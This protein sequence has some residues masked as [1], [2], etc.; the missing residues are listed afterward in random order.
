MAQLTKE[1]EF[2][3]YLLQHDMPLNPMIR[4]V[5][6]CPEILD[7]FD[8]DEIIMVSPMLAKDLKPIQKSIIVSPIVYMAITL[9]AMKANEQ[10]HQHI[11]NVLAGETSEII[12]KELQVKFR[13][14]LRKLQNLD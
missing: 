6:L 1:E 2:K 3:L 4:L 7:E 5:K 10:I 9:S 12:S 14:M 8:F 11:S 13:L